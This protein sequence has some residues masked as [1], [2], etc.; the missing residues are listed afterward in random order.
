MN[1]LPVVARPHRDNLTR[2]SP[3]RD[4]TVYTILVVDD[5]PCMRELVKVTFEGRP[6][7][8]VGAECGYQA[9]RLAR[10]IQPDLMLLDVMMP[11]SISGLD[12]CTI[13][14]ADEVTESI[15]IIM[16]SALAD[17]QDIER[18]RE[19]GADGYVTKPFRIASL[20]RAVEE[21]LPEPRQEKLA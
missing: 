5:D 9:V 10:D 17:T 4:T 20:I 11:H 13:L 12:V 15:P 3:V 8:I 19:A 16:V 18:A 14:K 6:Y 21:A 2:T 7:R 1:L